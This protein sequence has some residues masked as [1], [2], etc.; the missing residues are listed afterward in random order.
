MTQNNPIN[1]SSAFEV[2]L[3]EIEDEET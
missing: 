2:L 1:V 3:G